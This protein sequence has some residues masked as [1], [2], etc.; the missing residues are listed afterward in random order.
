M[1]DTR[2]WRPRPWHSPL[3]DDW[4]DFNGHLRDAFYLL[5]ASRAV[6]DLMDQLGLDAAYR[7]ATSGTLYTLE[8]HV[9][10]LREVKRADVV[11]VTTRPV[12]VDAKRLLARC[13]I[14]CPRLEGPAAVVEMLLLHVRQQPE[15]KS[16]PFP[17]EVAGRLAA[18]LACDAVDGGAHG[19]RVIALRP[20][21]PPAA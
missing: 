19:S 20:P 2:S 6:D 16:A 14:G 10:F 12:A 5:L 8:L 1:S 21:G 15:P 9:H 3:Q 4:I 13:E 11:S 17:D 7:A 18:W